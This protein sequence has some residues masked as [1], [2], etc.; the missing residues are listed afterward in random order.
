M[1]TSLLLQ[2][3]VIIVLVYVIV[4][5]PLMCPIYKLNFIKVYRK[6][7][8]GFGITYGFKNPLGV[9]EHILHGKGVATVALQGVFILQIL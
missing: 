1:F 4:I 6:T 3:I 2:Y 9:L 8:I 5:N 7:Y